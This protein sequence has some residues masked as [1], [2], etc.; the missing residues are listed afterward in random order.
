MSVEPENDVDN[1]PEAE[2]DRSFDPEI[3]KIN[4]AMKLIKKLSPEARAY[5][6]ARLKP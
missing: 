6:L 3:L 1:E 5:V 4:Q 2:S